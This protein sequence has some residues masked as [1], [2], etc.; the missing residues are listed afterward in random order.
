MIFFFKALII[1]PYFQANK[2]L[3]V[4]IELQLTKSDKEL[5]RTKK[6]RERN[7]HVCMENGIMR[8]KFTLSNILILR[9]GRLTVGAYTNEFDRLHCLRKLESEIRDFNRFI[10]GL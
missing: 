5:K 1:G 4:N 7:V 9:Q 10:K 8:M 3:Q 2:E 6:L